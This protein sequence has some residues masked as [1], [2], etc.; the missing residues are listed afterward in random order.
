MPPPRSKR[1]L[2]APKTPAAAPLPPRAHFEFLDGT[3][4]K[5]CIAGSFND[6]RPDATE[7]VPMGSGK[8]VRDLALAPGAYEYQLVVDREWRADP[9]ARQSVPNPFGG[10]NSLLQVGPSA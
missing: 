3:A 1:A 10:L 9:N 8:W 6:W 4:R 5:V 2:K 7:M